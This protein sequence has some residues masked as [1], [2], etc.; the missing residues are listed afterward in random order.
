MN[1]EHLREAYFGILGQISKTLREA[2]ETEK[3]LEKIAADMAK[4]PTLNDWADTTSPLS[5]LNRARTDLHQAVSELAKA[6]VSIK[7]WVNEAN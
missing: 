1:D 5:V 6:Y 3:D 7:C 4:I 2:I